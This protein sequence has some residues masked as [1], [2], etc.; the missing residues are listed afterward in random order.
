MYITSL[1]RRASRLNKDIRLHWGVENKLHWNLDVIFGED[2]SRK[3]V[4]N[5]SENFSIIEKVALAM[6]QAEKTM[7]KNKIKKMLAATLD[8]DYRELVLNV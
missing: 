5:A 6:V 2:A 1:S 7:K 8:S 4:A 3:R